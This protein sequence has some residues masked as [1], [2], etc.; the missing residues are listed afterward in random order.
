MKSNRR[1][2]LRDSALLSASLAA[3]PGILVHAPKAHAQFSTAPRVIAIFASGGWDTT[4]AIDPKASSDTIDSATDDIQTVGA[5][6]YAGLSGGGV[7]QVHDYFQAHH[8]K[9][10]LVRG[11]DVRS[12]AHDT[13]TTRMW[14]GGANVYQPDFAAVAA[15]IHGALLPLPYVLLTGSGFIGANAAYSARLGTANQVVTLLDEDLAWNIDNISPAEAKSYFAP[16]PEKETLIESVTQSRS[17]RFK[18]YRGN[19]GANKRKIDNFRDSLGK[20]QEV[21]AAHAADPNLL[22]EPSLNKGLT[23]NVTLALNLLQGGLSHSISMKDDLG[24][25]SHTGNA[26]TQSGNHGTLFNALEF[27]MDEL[28]TREF[29]DSPGTKMIDHTIVVVFSEMGRTPKLSGEGAAAG[30]DHWGYTSAM[31]MGAG[32][33]SGTY[34][35]TDTS[36][37]GIRPDFTTGAIDGSGTPKDLGAGEFIAGVLDLAEVPEEQRGL[38]ETPFSPY[39]MS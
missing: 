22:G 37:L 15:G 10:A 7:Q 28:A 36:M 38:T 21:R 8:Q 17:N 12:I 26:G 2:F 5:L 33:V 25:D 1:D 35:G 32:V 30:K 18:A 9:T 16:S 3:V 4:Y 27:L 11:I 34:G 39:K 23:D 13:C 20:L 31:V 19:Y 6:D 14:T 29:D 24:W